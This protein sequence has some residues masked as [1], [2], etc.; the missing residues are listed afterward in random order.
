MRKWLVG[1]L[2]V[3]FIC[4]LGAAGV[5]AGFLFLRNTGKAGSSP[6][7]DI[8]SPASSDAIATGKP[9]VI[10]AMTK[11]PDGIKRIEFWFDQKLLKTHDSPWEEGITPLTLAYSLK[12]EQSGAHAIIVRAFDS[13][14]HSGQSSLVFTAADG[15]D[16][17]QPKTYEIEAGDTVESI[18]A[19]HGLTTEDVMAAL[20]ED[21]DELPPAGSEISLSPPV[22]EGEEG[23]EPE[24]E[25][26]VPA[27]YVPELSLPPL[28]T[29]PGWY[30]LLRGI[31]DSPVLPV[32]VLDITTFEVD[33]PYDGVYCYVSAGDNPVIRVPG[34][35][36]FPNLEGNYWD[37]SEW[38]SAENRAMFMTTSGNLRLRMNCMG[39]TVDTAGG[40]A[41]NL[42]T[43]DI[44]RTPAEFASG[45]IDEQVTGPEG[46]F[47]LRYKVTD[48]ADGRG[49]GGT[50]FDYLYLDSS[51]YG[52]NEEPLVPN[53]HVLLEFR[54]YDEGRHI[55]PPVLDGFHIY[56]NGVKWR[57][58]G[59]NTER[60]IVWDHL[61]EAG[62]C[63]EQT[64]FFVV[65][66]LGDPDSPDATITSLPILVSGYCPAVYKHVTVRFN[67]ILY[68]CIDVD[69]PYHFGSLLTGGA[70]SYGAEDWGPGVYGGVNVN[71]IRTFDIFYPVY[72]GLSY[73]FPIWGSSYVPVRDLMLAPSESL[74]ISSTMWDYDV[75]DDS[76]PFCFD[77]ISYSP[78]DL[79]AME[80]RTTRVDGIFSN[81]NWF[82]DAEPID[83]HGG[84][85]IIS[86]DITVEEVA[87]PPPP[88]I[89]RDT[90]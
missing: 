32:G 1:I 83:P 76:D 30:N 47:K 49:G 5:I 3:L 26:V 33:R 60:Y 59:P 24:G 64:E 19:A 63:F 58:T 73:T 4:I 21:A 90:P 28:E 57:S 87:G 38:F 25:T 52:V 51:R 15:G 8:L 7:V 45:W 44:S 71:G 85:C 16:P 2:L 86:Y 75:W 10:Q 62:S 84:E 81:I 78:A 29:M 41:Y 48:P 34:T 35:G 70:C 42:G 22:G 72:T 74:T 66:Y 50:G 80:G 17:F 36:S 56:R 12:V 23:D 67:S 77:E 69:I 89:F 9:L 68:S 55:T 65:G 13:G 53:P 27:E 39:Y 37:V 40:V 43:L 79:Q 20:P 88:T 46:W 6:V 61:W 11:D 54:I 14:G 31:L 82:N 18:A